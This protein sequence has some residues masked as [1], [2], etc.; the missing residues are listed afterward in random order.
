[1]I[2]RIHSAGLT[3]DPPTKTLCQ[4]LRVLQKVGVVRTLDPPVLAPLPIRIHSESIMIHMTNGGGDGEVKRCRRREMRLSETE[5]RGAASPPMPGRGNGFAPSHRFRWT[6]RMFQQRKICGAW[7][8]STRSL[9]FYW[10]FTGAEPLPRLARPRSFFV[11]S[12]LSLHSRCV[13]I[14]AINF[15]LVFILNSDVDSRSRF[16]I[17]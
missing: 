8:S 12:T 17:P 6:A 16:Q 5:G 13:V 14:V 4:K 1:M 3:V 15:I 11:R 2:H 9:E 7:T 10:S